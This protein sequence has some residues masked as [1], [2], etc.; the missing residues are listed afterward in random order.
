MTNQI[1][2]SSIEDAKNYFQ[3][4]IKQVPADGP[5]GG[6]AG[7][8]PAQ[9]GSFFGQ[10]GTLYV[11]DWIGESSKIH[12]QVLNMGLPSLVFFI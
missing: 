7:V 3:S 5:Y 4:H 1:I 6:K 10:D 2:L 8:M 9:T 12:V 11:W